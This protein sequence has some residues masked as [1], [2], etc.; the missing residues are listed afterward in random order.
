MANTIEDLAACAIAV[1]VI[2]NLANKP[3]I[4]P[5]LLKAKFDKEAAD[6]LAYQNEVV[7]V[8]VNE[9]IAWIGTI[10]SA[11]LARL[12]GLT[13]DL[14]AIIAARPPITSGADVPAALASGNIYIRTV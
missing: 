2:R 4:G 13:A 8:K 6:M 3:N 10:S 1:N 12:T 14:T 5:E 7:R 11:E 9:I